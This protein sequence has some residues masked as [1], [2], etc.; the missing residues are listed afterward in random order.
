MLQNYLS[1]TLIPLPFIFICHVF[2]N[3]PDMGP[4][5]LQPGHAVHHPSD[6]GFVNTVKHY[7]LGKEE[8][9]GPCRQR[10][11]LNGPVNSHSIYFVSRNHGAGSSVQLKNG[12]VLLRWAIFSLLKKLGGIG[13]TP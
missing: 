4:N 8:K 12:S 1:K 13:Q 5:D 9:A 2:R 11:F 10:L 6:M 3:P 7:L